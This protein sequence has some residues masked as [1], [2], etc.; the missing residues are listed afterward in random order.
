MKKIAITIMSVIAILAMMMSLTGCGATIEE[1]A[2]TDRIVR[3]GDYNLSGTSTVI[4]YFD[5]V[6]GSM[7]QF[8]DG[9]KNGASMHMYKADGTIAV[10]S[11]ETNVEKRI[12][13]IDDYTIAGTETVYVYYDVV[14]GCMYHYLDGYKNGGA[15]V[16]YNAD[17]SIATYNE[18]DP[19]K[20]R[21][22]LVDSYSIGGTET[23]YVYYDTVTGVMYQF[24]DG[25]KNGGATVMRNPDGTVTTYVEE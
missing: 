11:K 13:L 24:V 17:G 25:Y 22:K 20:D 6:T 23:V 5:S 1:K 9:Y 18:N 14:E 21:M 8:I 7:Y 4:T 15:S 16:M 19:V 10:Y 2:K 12:K 3:I